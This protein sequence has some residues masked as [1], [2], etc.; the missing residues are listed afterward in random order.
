MATQNYKK[1]FDL[2]KIYKDVKAYCP[3]FDRERLQRAFDFAEKAHRGQY[4]KDGKTPYI[5]HPVEAMRI[6]VQLHA[7]EDTLISTLLHD[8][9]EDTEHD[10]HEVKTL[11]GEKVA[12]LVDGITKLSK[13][14]YHQNMPERQVESLKKLLLHSAEDLRVVIIKLADRL[15]NMMTLGNITKEKK[16]IRIATETLEIYV[17]IANLLGIRE[18]KV[19]LEDLCFKYLFPSEYQDV[20]K[21]LHSGESSKSKQV[22]KFIDVVT[23]ACKKQQISV[24]VLPREKNIYSVYKTM[25]AKGRTIEDIDNRIAV[26]IITDDVPNC[27]QV[28]G[29]VHGKYLP[30]VDRFKDYIASPKSNGYQSLHTAVF[31]IDGVLTEVQIKTK[32]MN[33]DSEYGI[34]ARFFFDKDASGFFA[35]ESNRTEWIKKILE[36]ER[37]DN[38]NDGFIESL[39]LD[40]FQER[41]FAFTPKGEPIDLPKG[42]TALDF[43]YAI[44]T[45]IGN[46]ACKSKINGKTRS[47]S[48]VLNTRDVVEVILSPEAK[49]TLAWL[50][51]AKTNLAKNRILDYLK[52]ID[53]EGQLWAGRKMFQKELDISGLGLIRDL[54]FKKLKPGFVKEFGRNFKSMQDLFVSI[55]SG[56]IKASKVVKSLNGSSYD[57]SKRGGQGIRVLIKIVAKNRFGL[58]RDISDVFYEN[59]IDM[60]TLKGWASKQ[61]ADAYFTA[62]VKVDDLNTVSYLFDELEQMEDVKH[63]YRVSKK[64]QFLF[65]LAMALTSVAWIVHPFFLRVLAQSEQSLVPQFWVT[66]LIYIGGISLIGMLYWITAIVSKYFPMLRNINRRWSWTLAFLIPILGIGVLAMEIIYFKFELSWTVVAFEIMAVYTYL[67]LNYRNYR[68]FMKKI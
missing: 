52:K 63:V 10:I 8:V 16:R 53:R 6:L 40:I 47:I 3:N 44:H 20:K 24:K 32:K 15:H 51:F 67:L 65:Y 45:E 58:L 1:Y 56:E 48:T 59:V 27:Y 12:F 4:R 23:R 60:Y 57:T 7:D 11:F 28:L 29:I 34:A 64:G 30:K 22:E 46:Q 18:I 31:G 43:A 25:C 14:H 50:S 54:S 61:E 55:G 39:K 49:P 9:P 41:I 35:N 37:S 38:G 13:V 17:P 62:D 5:S 2:K 26:N 66:S 19:K 42:A 33:V 36:L 68:K 21:K